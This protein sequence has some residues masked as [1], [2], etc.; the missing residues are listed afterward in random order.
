M[1]G[2]STDRVYNYISSWVHINSFYLGG[3]DGHP[4]GVFWDGTNWWMVGYYSDTVYKYNS[5]WSYTSESYDISGQE[6]DPT[7]IF[8]AA[9]N[10]SQQAR[11][12]SD[13]C[14]V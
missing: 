9:I 2:S 1:T 12:K 14:G 13:S 4:N 8:W 10:A 7:D 11:S 3:Q 5:T 6:T